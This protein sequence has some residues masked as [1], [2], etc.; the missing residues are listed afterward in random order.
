MMSSTSESSGSDDDGDFDETCMSGTTAFAF[1]PEYTEDEIQQ[2]LLDHQSQTES[3]TIDFVIHSDSSASE[4]GQPCNCEH[5]AEM[6]NE[7]EQVCC[8]ANSALIGDKF[9]TEKCIA[10][11]IAFRDVCL[12]VNVLQAALGTWR[13]FTDNSLNI[14]NKSYR[15]IAYR[16]YISWIYGWLGKD[17][18]RIIPAC[19]VKLIRDTFPAKDG[20]YVPFA[21]RGF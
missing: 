16:Q 11:T 15:F 19:V 8:R 3:D 6:E 13:T 21:D 5:C 7:F 20:V 18:R 17:V 9:N 14:S 10:Q 2:R 1:E 4:D 12:N